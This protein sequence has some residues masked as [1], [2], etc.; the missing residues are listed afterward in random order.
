MAAAT[1]DELGTGP[2]ERGHGCGG[3]ELVGPATASVVVAAGELVVGVG[4]FGGVALVVHGDELDLLAVDA[5]L[6]VDLGDRELEAL[7][8][9][10][11]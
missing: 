8:S 2:A 9:A 3:G 1:G 7:T 10:S 6:G 5:A 4:G 11:P